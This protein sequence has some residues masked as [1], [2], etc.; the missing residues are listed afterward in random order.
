MYDAQQTVSGVQDKITK[1]NMRE[2][3]VREVRDIADVSTVQ[4]IAGWGRS[5]LD[6]DRGKGEVLDGGRRR[7]GK[8]E[9]G[10]KNSGKPSV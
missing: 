3:Q 10:A 2:V 4:Q 1:S 8:G 7:S 6:C 5:M 9:K